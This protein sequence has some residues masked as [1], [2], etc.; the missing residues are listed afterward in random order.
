[1]SESLNIAVLHLH[2]EMRQDGVGR[3][4]FVG[5]EQRAAS[6]DVD[7]VAMLCAA[8]G[9]HHI[10]VIVFLVYVW[11]FRIAS[12]EPCAKSVHIAYAL[13]GTNV[14][15]ADVDFAWLDSWACFIGCCFPYEIAFPFVPKEGRV[16]TA[17]GKVNEYGV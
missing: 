13:T 2:T 9:K 12:T 10:V 15:F 3:V 5:T 8:F 1:M 14:Y 17:E 11:P 4:R 16:A 7:V 6:Q